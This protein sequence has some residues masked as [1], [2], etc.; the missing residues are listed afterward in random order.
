MRDR[1][2]LSRARIW[3]IK[4]HR[5][6]GLAETCRIYRIAQESG[7]ELWAGTMPES[8]IGSQA[9]LA[10]ASLPLCVYPSDLEPSSRW[11]GRDRDVVELTMG[12]DGRM[13]V[14]RQSVA[15]LLDGGRFRGVTRS[16]RVR[17]A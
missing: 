14:P 5:V 9:P 4:V 3:N 6:G 2:W 1:S 13:A 7:A 17:N 16:L 15:R 12:A 8:G 11:F 10:V